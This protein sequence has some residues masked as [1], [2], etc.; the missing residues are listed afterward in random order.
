MDMMIWGGATLP[1]YLKEEALSVRAT[2][3]DIME[4]AAEG[5]F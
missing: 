2:I 1:D 3:R 5:D 4:R